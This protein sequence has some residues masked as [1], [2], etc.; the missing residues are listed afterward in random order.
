MRCLAT[1]F[2]AAVLFAGLPPAMAQ[3]KLQME[4]L[5][6][7]IFEAKIIAKE[8]DRDQV[9]EFKI[10]KRTDTVAAA[11]GVKFGVEFLLTGA[12]VGK[13]VVI[14]VVTRF[15]KAGILN[16]RNERIFDT[17]SEIRVPAGKPAIEGYGFD[18]ER[19]LVP[20]EW[21]FEF[22]DGERKLGERKFTVTVK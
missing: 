18:D 3:Q 22:Y 6:T 16:E 10:I 20:G 5:S 17:E 14:R 13:E 2:A 15:P 9:G 1:L 21:V 11:I 12:P 19:E 8:K 4:V 7:G